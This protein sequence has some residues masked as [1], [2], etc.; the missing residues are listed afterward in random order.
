MVKLGHLRQEQDTRSNLES[1]REGERAPA[2][3]NEW[4]NMSME[5]K[6]GVSE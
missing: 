5:H 1:E 6:E 2:Q 4:K 3:R